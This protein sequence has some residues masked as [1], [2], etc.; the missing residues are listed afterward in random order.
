M[1][2]TTKKIYL[3]GIWWIWVSAIARYYLSEWWDIHWSDS[4][5]SELIHELQKEWCN[6]IIGSNK[7]RIWKDTNLVVYTEAIPKHQQELLQA[8]NLNIKT[9]K[10]NEALGDIV[11]N[12]KLI[13]ITG[14]HGKSTTTSMVSL[15]L[16]NSQESFFSIIG[17]LLKEFNGK[18]FY[19][20]N[21]ALKK[22]EYSV[23]EACEYKEHF[24]VYTPS[25]LVITNIEFDHAD[26]F[27]N[28]KN[29][30]EAYEKMIT[31]VLPWGFVILDR[32]D[33]HSQKLIGIRGDITFIENW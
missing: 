23:I 28:E 10:Y 18:N 33:T 5:D 11:N 9:R 30:V 20:K 32:N 22:L 31:K 25:V 27:K 14:T 4:T 17:T 12:K 6:I 15:V 3:I 21:S 19:R 26:Y 13:A 2:I 7:E 16:K 24:L 8:Q 29:Y 1:R